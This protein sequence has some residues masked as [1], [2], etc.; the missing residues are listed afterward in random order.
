GADAGNSD[1]IGLGVK[2]SGRIEGVMAIV[3]G[4][5]SGTK[6]TRGQPWGENEW[7]V[8]ASELAETKLRPPANFSGTMQY[9]VALKMPDTKIA[10]RQT[11]RLQWSQAQSSAPQRKLE[12]DEI[13]TMLR[14]G[15]TLFENGDIAGARLLLQ[16]AAEGGSEEAAMAMAATYDPGVMKNL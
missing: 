9:T 8:P 11:L 14:R 10:D 16:L 12:P 7:I 2:I 3:T 13:A 5:V 4:L 6:L 15:E 1:E